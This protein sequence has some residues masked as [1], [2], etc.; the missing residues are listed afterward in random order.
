LLFKRHIF[1]LRLNLMV[2]EKHVP[3]QPV[4]PGRIW[5]WGGVHVRREAP[6]NF[7]VLPLQYF[8]SKSAAISRFGERFRDG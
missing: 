5:N 6:G 7:V 3:I 8:G 4:A 1:A 2:G